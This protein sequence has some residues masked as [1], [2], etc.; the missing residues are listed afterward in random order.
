MIWRCRSLLAPQTGV[1]VGASVKEIERVD[2]LR[3]ENEG[4][5]RWERPEKNKEICPR[6][7]GMRWSRVNL[8]VAWDSACEGHPSLVLASV[9][10]NVFR[11]FTVRSGQRRSTWPADFWALRS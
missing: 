7:D 10:V 3:N 11:D 6:S 4:R 9:V 1:A 8:A 2:V 5:E